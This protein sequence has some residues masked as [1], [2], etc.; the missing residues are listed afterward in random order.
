[1]LLAQSGLAAL[2]N[3]LGRTAEARRVEET[4]LRFRY[5]VGN[6]EWI[7]NGHSNLADYIIADQDEWI[8]ALAHRLAGG[9]ILAMMGSGRKALFLSQ[10]SRNLQQAG[11]LTLPSDI[12]A[13]CATVEKVEGVRF[14][15]L[16]EQLATGWVT[17]D[18]LLQKILAEVKTA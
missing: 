3:T 4:S 12:A 2:E 14:R 13:L 11:R 7:A 17:G 10:L 5:I 15:E 9:L 6:P 1:M 16:V 8:D 18:E